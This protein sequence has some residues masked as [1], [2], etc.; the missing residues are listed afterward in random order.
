MHVLLQEWWSNNNLPRD[1]DTCSPIHSDTLPQ[2]KKGSTKEKAKK[3]KQDKKGSS[4][5]EGKPRRRSEDASTKKSPKSKK[6]NKS[7]SPSQPPQWPSGDLFSIDLPTVGACRSNED[8]PPLPIPQ[9]P[10]GESSPCHSSVIYAS[11]TPLKDEKMEMETTLSADVKRG[12][13][14]EELVEEPVD[15]P[16]D[17][18]RVSGTE[19]VTKEEPCLSE[20]QQRSEGS[21]AEASKEEENDSWEGSES[22]SAGTDILRLVIERRLGNRLPE[23]QETGYHTDSTPDRV[24]SDTEQ[25]TRAGERNTA[26]SSGVCACMCLSASLCC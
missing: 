20:A 12:S 23:D 4:Q 16:V 7:L 25:D 5:S 3:R 10:S 11:H 17:L 18:T 2:N 13:G 24:A 9:P 21:R 26:A 6:L 15:E 22:G 14:E 1:N 8:M 19:K